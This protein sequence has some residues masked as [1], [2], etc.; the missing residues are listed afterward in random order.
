MASTS[1]KN[2]ADGVLGVTGDVVSK[3]LTNSGVGEIGGKLAATT[4]SNEGELTVHN[5]LETKE[6]TNI[7]IVEVEGNT[8]AESITNDETITVTGNF[9]SNKITNNKEINVN[10]SI[11]NVGTIKA[12]DSGDIKLTDSTLNSF[13]VI[14]NQNISAEQS[15]LNVAN[16]YN[17]VNDSLTMNSS[18]LNLGELDL[19]PLHVNTMELTNSTVNIPSSKVDFTTNTMGRITVEKAVSDNDSVINLNYLNTMNFPD[20]EIEVI[21]MGFADKAISE[22]VSYN[23]QN[24]MYAP[25]YRYGISYDPT[26][27]DMVFVRGGYFNP[28]TGKI[29]RPT[30]PSYQYSPSVLATGVT[31]HNTATSAMNQ[32][33]NY[34][35][36][37][38]DN[39]MNYPLAERLAVINKD[40]YALA[41]P[42][43]L[44]SSGPNIAMNTEGSSW[45]KP[46][47]NFET[48]DYKNGPKVHTTN[49]GSFAGFDTSIKTMKNGWASTYTGYIGYNGATQ[50]YGGVHT[51]LNG[52]MLGGTYT[53]YKDNF[54]S[55]T[56]LTAGVTL[57]EVNSMF[58]HDDI[59]MLLGGVANKTGY[60]FEF[61]EGRYIFQPNVLVSYSFV[62]SFDYTNSAGVKIKSDP[63]HAIQVAPG[64]RL[65]A[66]TRNGWQPYVAVNM[67][68]NF[69]DK[70]KVMADDVRL[71]GMSTR[72]YVQYGIGVQKVFKDNFMAFGQTMFQSGGRHGVS[73]TAGLRWML[74]SSPKQNDKVENPNNQTVSK[75]AKPSET[76]YNT[77]NGKT[78]LKQISYTNKEDI[79]SITKSHGVVK[80]L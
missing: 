23:G 25:I 31:A 61:K 47:A 36:Q 8:L 22:N 74:D 63:L 44:M 28:S 20:K 38:S 41:E 9:A 2:T 67:V 29:E 14:E 21:K 24:K 48:V 72:P 65:M 49:Y 5:G 46:Y 50:S 33:F 68:M 34:V 43:M 17:L 70:A 56:T 18:T 76:K 12:E 78:V 77:S 13:G 64:F 3:T 30:N 57:A 73:L 80:Q 19:K 16:P 75:Q 26:T 11:F 60:N 37:N 52:G 71:P 51:Y 42:D 7:G 10:K 32:V 54:F 69:M 45:Y 55:A 40:K 62:N 4:V 66:N 27:G 35:F 15:T 6:L 59:T 1:I 39:F 79:T 58:G 53:L